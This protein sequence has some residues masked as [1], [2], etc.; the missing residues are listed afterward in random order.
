MVRYTKILALIITAFLTFVAFNV[1]AQDEEED[2]ILLFSGK[3]TNASGGKLAGVSVEFFKDNV[4]FKKA[5]TASSGKYPA[6]EAEYG[7]VY[8]V[9]FSKDGYVS[10]SVVID[11]KKG[12]FAEDINEKKTYLDELG[13][14]L[15]NQQP[16]IDYSVVTSRP[17]AKAH[18]DP[19]TGSL[20]FDFG[21]IKTRKKEID[22]FI[23]ALAN[24]D[25]EHEQK[26]MQL[27][28]EGDN[29]I[30][31]EQYANAIAKYKEALKI[32]E[33]KNVTAKIA[34]AENKLKELEAQNKLNEE[35]NRA[36]KKG[37]QLLA[38]N[39]FDASIAEYNNAKAIKP[40]DSLPDEKIKAANDKQKLADE[41]ALFKEYN[42]KIR[43]A[44]IQFKANKLVEAEKLYKEALLI[45]PSESA[46]KDKIAEIETILQTRKELDEKY[47]NLITSGDLAMTGEKYDE[48]ISIFEDALT[49]KQNEAYP[50]NQ[51]AK[52]KEL[53]GAKAD[54]A[55]QQK[56]YDNLISNAT[57]EFGS[58]SWESAKSTF[59][60]ALAV[61]PNEQLPK[62]KIVEI[63]AKL[64]ELSAVKA[65][66][67]AQQKKYDNLI[68]KAT[69]EFGRESWES[70]KSTFKEALAVFP[71]EELPKDKIAELDAK[72][73]ELADVKEA[74]E[75][76]DVAEKT[77]KEE[78]DNLVANGNTQLQEGELD[79]AKSSFTEASK[80]YPK[81]DITKDKLLEVNAKI[82]TEGKQNELTAKYNKIIT[83]A[84]AARDAESWD[85]AKQLYKDA[86]KEKPPESY[87]QEQIDWINDKMKSQ[88]KDDLHIQ[89]QK[90]IDVADKMFV[91]ENYSKSME[92]YKRATKFETAEAYPS[93]KI[94]EIE[95]ILADNVANASNER[96]YS[97]L[98]AQA[99]NQFE[100]ENWADARSIYSKALGFTDK[101][102]P[103]DQIVEIDNKIN[104]EKNKHEEYE[105]LIR[106]ADSEFTAEDWQKSKSNYEKALALLTKDYPRKQINIIERKLND[107]GESSAL[108]KEY[109]DK[110]ALADAARDAENWDPAK[111]LYKEANKIK[112]SEPYPQ[113]QIKWINNQ[114]KTALTEEV[115]K[116]YQKIID[117]ADKL[118]GEE[119]YIKSKELYERAKGMKP[120]DS[121]PP[122][123]IK[124]INGLIAEKNKQNKLYSSY[125]KSGN[126]EFESKS[127]SRALKSFNN[128]LKVKPS[129]PYPQKKV[130]EIKELLNQLAAEKLEQDKLKPAEFV[131]DLY[132]EE[133]TGK[134][135]EADVK[136]MMTSGRIDDNDINAE[137][138]RKRKEG[139]ALRLQ[140]ST[141][142]QHELGDKIY[143]VNEEMETRIS[144]FSKDA[145]IQRESNAE[146]MVGYID[147]NDERLTNKINLGK[148][149][150]YDNGE[151]NETMETRINDF[152]VNSD[153]QRQDNV[154]SLEHFQEKEFAIKSI[155]EEIT[156][157]KNYNTFEEQEELIT[158][159][160]E[161]IVESDE[162]RQENVKSM[163]DY[164]Q[165]DYTEQG[166]RIGF[167]TD[168][169]YDNELANETMETRINDFSSESDED[170]QDNVVSMED[171]QQ[172]DYTEQGGRIGFGTDRTYDNELANETME[173]RINDFSSE[174]DEHRQ[175]NVE[176]M[177]DYQQDDYT[178]Q[179]DRI[180]FGTDRTYDN[181]L[182]NET[183]E[184]RINDFS[185]ESDEHRQD[186]VVSMEDYQQDDYTEQGGRIGFGTDRTYDNELANETM[187]TRINDFSS[188]SDEHRQDNVV[189]MED[190]Q[191][192]DYTEQGGRIG[193]G[194]DRTYDNELANETMETRINDFSSESDE[195]RQDNVKSMENYQQ[196]DYAE[197]GDR[198]DFGA[199]RTYGNEIA[200]EE[201]E[202]RISEFSVDADDTRERNAEALGAYE[203]GLK[204]ESSDYYNRN[205]DVGI[206][207][208]EEM[209]RVKNQSVTMFVDENR[210]K[211]STQYPEGITEKMFERRNGRGDVIEVTILRIIIKGVKGDEYKKVSAKW[212]TSYF[213]N[214]GIISE[215][216][217]DTET[218]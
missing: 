207:N 1:N 190:Y 195:H 101:Q 159:I 81:N 79:K 150:T 132:G 25:N 66:K 158:E 189:S 117:V 19:T 111:L 143:A 187:E 100:S 99:D 95:K 23:A 78:F 64:K 151:A 114:M 49:L 110:I 9:V 186:N 77:R 68:S 103:K 104:E 129:A 135:T 191:Q 59:K 54:K 154:K 193:F 7:H 15:I 169:T 122:K 120:G 218:N 36:I 165:G 62:D 52:A 197:Q 13:T 171:Y 128:A 83:Q 170:R 75:A 185:S 106:K 14:S 146:S 37:D 22:K 163:E 61:F 27:V 152:S 126:S 202:T 209:D 121:Y 200:N 172:G 139:E 45:K 91:D 51:I 156:L 160:N 63:D 148:D 175:D 217:W 153:I 176:S 70:A 204:D 167:G 118:F 5:S 11:A 6:V 86:N 108:D 30:S 210:Q 147:Q 18:I 93:E 46:P 137:T 119:D 179:G 65:D 149:V 145:D 192:G 194:T 123:Q 89:Y 39:D 198:I 16:N 141:D 183:M 125:I 199:D 42:D 201:M 98:I 215:Y 214:G 177:E 55:A 85:A 56:K 196:D 161:E 47:N 38:S 57:S 112:Y 10:K 20:G 34:D 184:T 127:Y 41:S 2:P 116:Q 53:S 142:N 4:S 60:E 181:E 32:K 17:V 88:L 124:K 29:A 96:E 74:N 50:K 33:D 97:S 212:G 164:Q 162:H 92:L 178:E 133:V 107:L 12:F 69:S 87:P 28:K 109:N 130:D 102:Y 182:A 48:A 72:L 71:N 174:S 168:R 21:Y 94:A 157:D 31:S 3:I 40:D 115:D 211:L 173:T 84:D 188:E 67:A 136:F 205:K 208:A 140:T 43:E 203:D 90:I 213:K 138:I 180:G 206:E 80:I 82:A 35:F 155:L 105:Q 58:E 76:A 113:E 73:K 216:I 24:A 134:Y 26:F 44:D 144:E 131:K 166:D 8:K